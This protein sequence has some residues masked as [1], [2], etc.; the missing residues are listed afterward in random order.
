MV[1]KEFY[2]RETRNTPSAVPII[3]RSTTIRIQEATMIT[4]VETAIRA[5]VRPGEVLPT[6]TGT[7]TFAVDQVDAQ[8]LSLLFGPKKTRTLFTW[9]CLEGIPG[10][11]RGRG[12]VP[13]GANR[14]VNSRYGLDGYLKGWIKRQTANYVAVVLE[15]ASVLELNRERPAHVRLSDRWPPIDQVGQ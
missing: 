6:P 15:R 7:A 5:S 3:G 11:L 9:R 13:V 4:S 1:T 12:W 8:G 10:Y 14:D 2:S